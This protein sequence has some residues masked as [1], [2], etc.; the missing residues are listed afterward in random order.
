LNC[1]TKPNELSNKELS[2]IQPASA[3]TTLP[4]QYTDPPSTLLSTKSYKIRIAAFLV[5]ES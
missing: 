3:L 5:S 4:I 2:N 1:G